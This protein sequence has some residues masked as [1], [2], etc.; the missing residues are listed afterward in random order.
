MRAL[1]PA[2]AH[3]RHVHAVLGDQVE[4]RIGGAARESDER[5]AA[6]GPNFA[7]SSS[8]SYLRPGIT[9][10]PLRPEPP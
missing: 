4:H 8:G 9:W 10:P 6:L 5:R 2:I 1:D 3:M 7:S